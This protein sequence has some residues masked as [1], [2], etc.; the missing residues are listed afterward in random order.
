MPSILLVDDTGL[1]RGA[2][3]KVVRRTG[4]ETLFAS[5]GT[6]A[7]DLA[8][9]ERPSMIVVS[10]GMKGMTGVDLCRV[11]KAD[12]AF[13]RT[14]IVLLAQAGAEGAAAKAGADA[15]LSLPL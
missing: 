3:E 7:L 8:R 2:A 5:G 12:P 6:E 9:R 14:P 13:A 4:C 1:F 10:A 15:T 11:L